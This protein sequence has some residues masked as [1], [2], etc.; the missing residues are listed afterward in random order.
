M[1]RA[2]RPGYGVS[3]RVSFFGV[4]GSCPCAGADYCGVGGN[5]SCVLVSVDG[6]PP[7]VLD[8]GTGLRALGETLQAAG[9][10]DR[11]LRVNAL[12]T[13]LHFA[14]ILGLP[15]FAPLHEPGA[16]L[17][18]YG[19]SQQ[20]ELLRTALER[21]VEPPFFPVK[22]VE[23]GGELDVRELSA[24]AGAQDGAR[25]GLG[26]ISVSARTVPH[27]GNTLGFRI[28]AE[29]RVLVYV[30]DHQAPADRSTVP[31]ALRSLCQGADL[32]LHDAQYSDEEFETKPDW[33]HSTVGYAVKVAAECGVKRLYLF[34][35]DPSHSDSDVA[36]LASVARRHPDAGRLGE[37]AVAQEGATLE[38]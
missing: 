1:E 20:G 16:H 17:T 37:I 19:P 25:L 21:A 29:G 8:L 38:V 13:H 28:E 4:R 34:H 18:L 31:D 2:P 22:M 15:F 30:P 12:V 23:F 11:P 10:H 35:H 6:E 26:R 9:Q 32:L 3:M 5:T 14:H 36:E 24:E 33:G 27:P 7:L